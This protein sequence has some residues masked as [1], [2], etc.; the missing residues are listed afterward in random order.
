[1]STSQAAA[2]ARSVL[3]LS[4]EPLH[5]SL[6]GPARRA[7]KLAEVVAEHCAVTLAAPDPSVFPPGPFR[8]VG[9]GA[10]HDQR[11]DEALTGHDVVVVQTLPSPRQLLAVRRR[12]PRLVV[13]LLAPLALEASQM[14]GDP[15]TRRAVVRWRAREMVAHMAVADLVVC[16]NDKQR[17]LLLGAGLA[18]GLLETG[19]G[20]PLHDRIVVVPHGLDPDPPPRR[21]PALRTGELAR[22]G[23]R[24]AVWGG[25]MWGWL[26]P[27]TAIEAMERLRGPRPDLK[28]AFIG[29]EHP[30]PAARHAHE[31]MAAR[32]VAF[33]RERGLEDTVVF[34]PRWL[35]RD[36]YV[37]QLSEAD[38]GLSLHGTALEGRFAS[39]TRV[40]DYLYAR[41]PVVCTSGDTMS[42]VVAEHALGRVVAPGDPDAVAAALDAV[43]ASPH[44]RDDGRALDALAWRHVARPLVAFC[45]EP[46]AR[47]GAG[48]L[49]AVA[50]AAGEYPAFLRATQRTEGAGELGRALRRRLRRLRPR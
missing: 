14:A 26:D 13:D 22:E 28:L 24:I 34:R 17:D 50:V 37:G 20:A 39:R 1:V 7:V 9:T 44:P 38:V 19:R 8:A 48:G 6:T 42:E 21:A 35:D 32:T 49:G 16:S 11:L 12:A 30:D 27:F 47:A 36:D 25:G 10:A 23:D 43:T 31:A 2:P 5:A 45:L 46:G 41:L 29:F 15:A 40:V 33:A 4:P 3:F 18:A